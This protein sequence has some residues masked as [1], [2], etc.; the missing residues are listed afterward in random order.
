MA[1]TLVV[2]QSLPGAS[3]ASF[4]PSLPIT[5]GVQ[6]QLFVAGDAVN[7]NYFPIISGKSLLFVQNTDVSAHTVTIHSVVDAQGR[8]GD[9]TTYSVPAG[10]THIFGP[11]TTTPAGWNQTSPAGLWVDPVSALLFLSVVTNP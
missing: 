4:F 10:E 6:K 1:R 8:L 9:I 3:G 5:P 7:N 2:A 11:F